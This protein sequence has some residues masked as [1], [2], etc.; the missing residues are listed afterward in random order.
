MK[1][2][3]HCQTNLASRHYNSEGHLWTWSQFSWS[4]YFIACQCTLM[5]INL[6][7]EGNPFLKFGIMATPASGQC[8]IYVKYFAWLIYH[9][10]IVRRVIRAYA[11][12]N[13]LLYSLWP[14]WTSSVG[15]KHI[16]CEID[17]FPHI[18]LKS[19]ITFP[20]VEVLVWMSCP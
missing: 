6:W 19:E 18:P 4:W 16:F 12:T 2:N 15:T 14:V 7:E 5:K 10:V 17:K 3:S 9:E 8:Q 20:S 1:G 11:R 13:R